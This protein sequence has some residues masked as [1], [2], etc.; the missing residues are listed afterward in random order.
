MKRESPNVASGRP[1]GVAA[2][3]F[4]T[5]PDGRAVRR[6]TLHN[7]DVTVEAIE[8]GAIITSLRTP[9]RRGETGD[10]VLG[11]D[12]L[13]GYLGPS[14][15]F[16]AVVGRF[17]NRIAHGRFVLDGVSYQL[18]QNDGKNHLHGGLRGFDKVLWS[19]QP[20]SEDGDPGLLFSY[21]S[22]DGEEGYPGE[23]A[24]LVTYVLSSTGE[25]RVRYAA[26][27]DRPTIVNLTQHS[28]FNLAA[29]AK[30]VLSHGL[31]VNASRYTPV[32]AG[33]IPTGELRDVA[34]T[35]FDFRTPSAIG[36]RIDAEDDQLAAAGGYDHNFVLDRGDDRSLVLAARVTE[37]TSGRT[38]EVRTTQ[39]GLQFYSGNFL[40]GSII[41]KRG[42]RYARRS[43]FCL[44]T[45]HYPDSPNESR[46]PSVVLRP[47]EEYGEETVFV[48]GR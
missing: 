13:D 37:P 31:T 18:A 25:L 21:V 22:A 16:G 4:G 45:Q 27:T 42:R 36:A 46:F 39:P 8:L 38:L 23:L 1:A 3:H 19:G 14:P 17:A 44:E 6:F 10:I 11:F 35:P 20:I 15:Y 32:D 7:G 28:Y 43:A 34:G 26:R 24:V 29:A 40:D 41:G 2:S 47:S 33:L 12:T 9:D 5:M 30:D 48:F